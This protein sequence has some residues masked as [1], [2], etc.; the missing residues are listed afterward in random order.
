[1]MV[2]LILFWRRHASAACNTSGKEIRAYATTET[3]VWPSGQT[4]TSKAQLCKPSWHVQKKDL[5]TLLM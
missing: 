2:P 3:V 1:M 5:C 4:T